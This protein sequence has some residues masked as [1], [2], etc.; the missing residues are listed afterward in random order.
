MQRVVRRLRHMFDPHT[1]ATGARDVLIERIE[2]AVERATRSDQ[3]VESIDRW[4]KQVDK[5]AE[6]WRKHDRT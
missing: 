2:Q 4:R 1:E 5:E 6:D 3:M